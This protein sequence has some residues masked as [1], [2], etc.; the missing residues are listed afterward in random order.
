MA[1]KGKREYARGLTAKAEKDIATVR[2]M[3]ALYCHKKHGTKKG[4]LCAECEELFEYARLRRIKCPH[5]D[6]K[7]SCSHCKI[8]CYKP[9]MKAKIREVMKFS[10]PRLLIYEPRAVFG[11]MFTG[12]HS[13]TIPEGKQPQAAK[14]G[15]VEKIP[16]KEAKSDD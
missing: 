2:L 1:A 3:I 8:H 6:G 13:K 11:H 9:E 10:G 4:E 5:G 12:Y 7:P 15:G 16:H 14:D